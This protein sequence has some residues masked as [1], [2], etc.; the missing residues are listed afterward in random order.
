MPLTL[1]AFGRKVAHQIF[2]CVAENV[3]AAGFIVFEIEFRTL[4]DGDQSSEFIHHF[5][6]LAQ[7]RFII[8]MRIVD[9]ATKVIIARICK[10]GNHLIHLFADVFVA[11]QSNKIIKATAIRNCDIGIFYALEFIGYILD[12]QKRQNIILILRGVHAASEFI[13]TCP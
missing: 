5:L 1:A 6:T 12:K 11:F 13:A 9:H 3:I 7:L 4:K 8:K 2:V 10:L